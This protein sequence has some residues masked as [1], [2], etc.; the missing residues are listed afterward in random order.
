MN[1]IFKLFF[2]GKDPR[3]A[4][5]DPEDTHHYNTLTLVLFWFFAFCVLRML[6]YMN[7]HYDIESLYVFTII[8]EYLM[9]LFTDNF[10]PYLWVSLF[11]CLVSFPFFWVF[12]Q[13][14]THAA[15][16]GIFFTPY[17]GFMPFGSGLIAY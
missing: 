10:L 8:F 13:T 15:L 5:L 16:F 17:L 2:D 9:L 14:K 1:L 11:V 3:D 4:F 12:K 7:K 6:V